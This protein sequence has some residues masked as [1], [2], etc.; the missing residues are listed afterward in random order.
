MVFLFPLFWFSQG[1]AKMMG[2]NEI[3]VSA[4]YLPQFTENAGMVHPIADNNPENKALQNFLVTLY[5]NIAID[6]GAKNKNS[7]P[8]K[9]I[10]IE[11]F[12]PVI[13]TSHA[14]I[15]WNPKW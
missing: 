1:N 15:L 9:G 2:N 14:V 13:E 7:C 8:N 12:I 10:A 3:A 6:M 11:S 5:V 4:G